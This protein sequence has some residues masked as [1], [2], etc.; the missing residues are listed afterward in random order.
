[1]LTP[2][3]DSYHCMQRMQLTNQ[4][5]IT[6]DLAKNGHCTTGDG[7]T[8]SV[9][10]GISRELSRCDLSLLAMGGCGGPGH[11]PLFWC[12]DGLRLLEAGSS[13]SAS[14]QTAVRVGLWGRCL[15]SWNVLVFHDLEP[16]VPNTNAL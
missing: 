13:K 11:S 4:V 9:H 8:R 15:G 2:A 16:S 7:V 14:Q 10:G 3:R 1:M 5:A 6:F 12:A